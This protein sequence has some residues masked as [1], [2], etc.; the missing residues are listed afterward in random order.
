[1]QTLLY[2]PDTHYGP[3]FEQVQ[4]GQLFSEDGKDFADAVPRPGLNPRQIMNQ[5]VAQS[6]DPNFNLHEFLA[7][8]FERPEVALPFDAPQTETIEE[9]I[10]SYWSFLTRFNPV[11]DITLIGLPNEY[12]V[13]GQ[14]FREMFYWDSYFAMLGLARAGKWDKIEGM[15]DNIVEMIDRFGHPLNFNRCYA[16][17]RSQ[18]PFLSDMV[19]LLASHYEEQ[20]LPLSEAHPAIKYLPAMQKEWRFLTR[21]ERY[22]REN[23]SAHTC[24]SSVRMPDGSILNRHFDPR[25]TPR[26]ES[27]REDVEMYKLALQNGVDISQGRFNQ[28][29]R[30]GAAS[31]ED[32]SPRLLKDGENLYTIQT[33]DL[34][35]PDYNSKIYQLEM[36]M[37]KSLETRAFLNDPDS[38]GS[39]DY[40]RAQAFYHRAEARKDSINKY[41]WD[42]SQGYYFDYN[43]VAG[44]KTPIVSLAAGAYPVVAG[45]TSEYQNAFIMDRW[46]SQLLQRGGLM[47]TLQRSREQ[48]S[49]DRGWAPHEHT[50]AEAADIAGNPDFAFQLRSRWVGTNL[51]LFLRDK[52]LYEKYDIATCD[53]GAGGEYKPQEGFA[54]TNGVLRN[55]LIQMAEYI[56]QKDRV[57]IA[58]AGAL[59]VTTALKSVNA[60]VEFTPSIN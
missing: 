26:P 46:R 16:D 14:R 60:R 38:I 3:L 48:W 33:L 59:A 18:P 58:A 36:Y 5:Y 19:K 20:G 56:A 28:H 40:I 9:Y 17:S 6:A 8:C 32:Y 23:S 29:M 47:T 49:D 37:A 4:L 12:I 43:F 15:I 22:L 30:G 35:M 25:Q 24:L 45:V 11:D 55:M 42:E 54:W 57:P 27:Y 39:K 31:G 52:K 50:A 10:D 2:S 41:C 7:E 53:V 51:L 21:G 34:V 44:E 13:P 1:M